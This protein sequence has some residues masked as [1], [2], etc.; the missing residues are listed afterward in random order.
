MKTA[1]TILFWVLA[2]VLTLAMA[3]YQRKTGPTYPVDG[4][5]T[6]AGQTITY[7]LLRS[8]GGPGDEIGRAHV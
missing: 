2:L 8:H 5:V 6:V 3:R 4:T 1:R 7:E